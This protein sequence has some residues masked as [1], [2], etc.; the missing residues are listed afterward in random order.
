ML[1][2]IITT[3]NYRFKRKTLKNCWEADYQDDKF[4]RN[5]SFSDKFAILMT[6]D[7][8]EFYLKYMLK[9]N[10]LFLPF[11][12]FAQKMRV[13]TLKI[14][15]VG[16]KEE[17]AKTKLHILRIQCFPPFSSRRFRESGLTLVLSP[18]ACSVLYIFL[19]TL[20]RAWARTLNQYTSGHFVLLRCS[21]KEGK[22]HILRDVLCLGTY[23]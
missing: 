7:A 19:F 22:Q 2:K 5:L 13:L 16:Q 10:K 20:Y 23:F 18:S 3:A 1:E 8:R 9:Q 4:L 15:R 12:C 17:P 14:A 6:C 21:R 11:N